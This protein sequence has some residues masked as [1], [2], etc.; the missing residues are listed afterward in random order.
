MSESGHGQKNSPQAFIVRSTFNDG[1]LAAP[2]Y[3]PASCHEQ[4]YGI[5]QRAWRE[6]GAG[7]SSFPFCCPASHAD[8]LDIGRNASQL[9][10]GRGAGT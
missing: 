7:S 8:V 2:Q 10:L 3:P 5:E 6:R 1:R 4:T 9:H